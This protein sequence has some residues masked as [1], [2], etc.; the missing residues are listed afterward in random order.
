MKRGLLKYAA[1]AVAVY[2][3]ALLALFP[4]S[5]ALRWFAPAVPG[6]AL[7]AADGTL[8][9]GRIGGVEYRG[10]DLG[11]AEWSLQPLALLTLTA[12]AE[13]SLD[14]PNGAPISAEVRAG[15]DGSAEITALHGAFTLADLERARLLPKNIASGEVIL[16]LE[17]LELLDGRP[18]AATGRGGLTNLRSPLLP[19]VPLGSYEGDIDTDDNG[20]S[21]VFRDVEAPL[22]VTGEA[23]LSPDGRYTV[24][25]SV[26]PTAETPEELRR[27]LALLGQPDASGR[28]SFR[29]SGT[30]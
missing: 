22:R 23:V 3:V 26:L 27:G 18:V 30:L 11:V 15:F 9:S 10:L 8:W 13:I 28:Y 20:I 5:L 19:G 16:N 21:V 2:L 14:R 1:L 29:F 12:A 17:R 24:S 7:G 25:G 6:L 4:A